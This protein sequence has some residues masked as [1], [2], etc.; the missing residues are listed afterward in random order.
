MRTLLMLNLLAMG[1]II[2]YWSYRLLRRAYWTWTV[3]RSKRKR[4]YNWWEE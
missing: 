1:S 4:I 2:A 3:Y